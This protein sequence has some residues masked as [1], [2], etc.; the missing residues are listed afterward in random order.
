MPYLRRAEEGIAA[1]IKRLAGMESV[2]PPIDFEKAVTWC[3]ERTG[4]SS[5]PVSVRFACPHNGMSAAESLKL[6]RVRGQEA[7][8]PTAK[9]RRATYRCKS[10]RRHEV[11]DFIYPDWKTGL[12]RPVF[13]RHEAHRKH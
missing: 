4:K 1:K 13:H 11:P 5:R 12:F 7:S 10:N 9:L 6:S 8:R 3:E 2:Y